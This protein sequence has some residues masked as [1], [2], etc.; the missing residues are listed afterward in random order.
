[1]DL[2]TIHFSDYSTLYFVEIIKILCFSNENVRNYNSFW[3]RCQLNL[4]DLHRNISLI[5]L[6]ILDHHRYQLTNF[7]QKNIFL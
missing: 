7:D 3:M 4:V 2:I 5:E 6:V 1:M